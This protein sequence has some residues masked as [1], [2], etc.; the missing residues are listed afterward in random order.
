MHLPGEQRGQGT[1]GDRSLGPRTLAIFRFG[2]EFKHDAR[3]PDIHIF[4]DTYCYSPSS[5]GVQSI[6][7]LSVHRPQS[8][9]A[10]E[11]VLIGKPIHGQE[12]QADP[13][14]FLSCKKRHIACWICDYGPRVSRA[15]PPVFPYE[16][17]ISED[18]WCWTQEL[19]I[20][21][22]GCKHQEEKKRREDLFSLKFNKAALKLFYA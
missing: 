17:N 5:W 8:L 7:R 6:H 16:L 18:I 11:R 20:T 13:S 3:E 4:G 15:K 21:R 9:G 10:E 12:S 1:E 2:V 14:E 19:S 22:E